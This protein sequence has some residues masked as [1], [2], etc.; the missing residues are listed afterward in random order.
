MFF[1]L[2]RMFIAIF[3]GHFNEMKTHE[4]DEDRK[5]LADT[6]LSILRNEYMIEK[7]EKKK[8]EMKEHQQLIK[9]SQTVAQETP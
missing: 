7:Y 9:K 5:G 2:L 4:S 6:I 1:V 8:L 3:D